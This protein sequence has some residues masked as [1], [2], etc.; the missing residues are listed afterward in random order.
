MHLPLPIRENQPPLL[1][2]RRHGREPCSTTLVDGATLLLKISRLPA[3]ISMATRLLKLIRPG[4]PSR[5]PWY[6]LWM[7]RTPIDRAGWGWM[8]R[9]PWRA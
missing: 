2:G 1:A 9:T 4:T 6:C 8:N 7:N 3:I 5:R